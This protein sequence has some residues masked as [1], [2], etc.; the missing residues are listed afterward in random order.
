[1]GA[2]SLSKHLLG[3]MACNLEQAG[4]QSGGSECR[5]TSGQD[6]HS[7]MA[8]GHASLLLKKFKWQ[9]ISL[10]DFIF[11]PF[12][13]TFFNWL[14]LYWFS[15]LFLEL[16]SMFPVPFPLFGVLFLQTSPWLILSFHSS[17]CS[18]T[19]SSDSILHL[20][21]PLLGFLPRSHHLTLYYTV[22]Y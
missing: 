7:L 3:N 19:T 16:P 5:W 6:C 14:Q 11:Y 1:M 21:I 22:V 8:S 2:K 9:L 20:S 13:Q 15:L 18:N 4:L 10:S 12:S 17:G